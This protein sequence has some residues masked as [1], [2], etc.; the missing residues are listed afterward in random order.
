MDENKDKL[1]KIFQQNVKGK[2][3]DISTKNPNHDG[4][5]G[6]WL[7]EQF[8]IIAN[9][10]NA[11]D[12]LGYELKNQTN[13]KITFGDWSANRYIFKDEID[14]NNYSSLF[15]GNKAHEKQDSFCKI[16]GESNQA[17]DG[18]YSWSGKPVPK[19]NQ[20]N[21]YG[22]ILIVDDNL[23]IKAIYSFSEDSRKDKNSIIPKELQKDG[24]VIAKWFGKNSPSQ[25]QKD[26]C[27]KLKLENKF[28]DK[29]WFIC[30]T[31][32]DG[33][34]QEICFGKPFNYYTWIELV[35]KGIVFFDSGMYE[36]NKRPYSQWRANNSYWDSQITERYR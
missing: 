12:I 28:N 24:I 34:Y 6:H 1:I 22:Q 25:K 29:G 4:K 27:L 33:V 26:K 35:K 7:E 15:S 21:G 18:R 10:N 2:K 11:P 9:G 16:F 8:N 32:S 31:N 19:I 23:D 20:Y 36:G 5:K 14:G 13:S 30:K 17:K 3:C